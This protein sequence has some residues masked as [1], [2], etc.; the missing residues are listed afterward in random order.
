MK[1]MFVILN[2]AWVAAALYKLSNLGLLPTTD[3]DWIP[4]Y[5]VP[6]VLFFFH[7]CLFFFLQAT[8]YSF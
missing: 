7:T 2:L 4:F 3:A 5:H 8:H 1:V 6:K